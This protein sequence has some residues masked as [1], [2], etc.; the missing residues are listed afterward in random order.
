M[1]MFPTKQNPVGFNQTVSTVQRRA[2]E[3]S[4][5][6]LGLSE[7]SS[8][9][10]PTSSGDYSTSSS[11]PSYSVGRFEEFFPEPV[12]DDGVY[13]IQFKYNFRYCSNVSGENLRVGEFVIIDCTHDQI[14]MGIVC[15]R[16]TAEEFVRNRLVL[17]DLVDKEDSKI[18]N[19]IRIANEAERFYLPIKHEQELKLLQICHYLVDRFY[20][21][22]NIYGVEFQFDGKKVSVFYT[23]DTRVDYKT[24]VK[25][26][27]NSCQTHIWMRKTNPGIKFVPKPFA[28]ESLITGQRNG[29]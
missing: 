3:A 21:P 27:F 15:N 1:R 29:F 28:I 13:Q 5:S 22:M 8:K 14:D 19:I 6:D 9:I 25:E 12:H 24:L 18:A 17:G 20:L 7:S 4:L 16:F 2:I 23:S 26:L 11:L 10:T